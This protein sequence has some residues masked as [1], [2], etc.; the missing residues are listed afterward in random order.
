MHH[1]ISAHGIT[2][3]YHRSVYADLTAYTAHFHP[4]FAQSRY[5]TVKAPSVRANTGTAKNLCKIQFS[6]LS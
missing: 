1:T 4:L 5:E 3:G 6:L 2:A